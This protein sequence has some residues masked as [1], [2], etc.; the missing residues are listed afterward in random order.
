VVDGAYGRKARR[1][2]KRFG[3]SRRNPTFT[4]TFRNTNVAYTEKDECQIQRCNQRKGI[5]CYE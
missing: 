4:C 3:L 1:G 2:T 5:I